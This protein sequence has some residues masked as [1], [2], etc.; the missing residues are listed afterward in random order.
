V[1][2]LTNFST[3]DERA[4]AMPPGRTDRNPIRQIELIKLNKWLSLS[5]IKLP[6]KQT[7]FG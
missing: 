1:G 4:F 3:L 5:Q 7:V 2:C 6:A